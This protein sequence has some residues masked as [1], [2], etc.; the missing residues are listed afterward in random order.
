MLLLFMT[1][2][3]SL[4]LHKFSC[5]YCLTGY[6]YTQSK[7]SATYSSENALGVKFHLALFAGVIDHSVFSISKC[8][9]GGLPSYC[10]CH[11]GGS[12]PY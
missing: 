2:L 3:P 5:H 4:S 12:A 1:A 10:Y 11:A 8:C 9:L 7:V 6:G